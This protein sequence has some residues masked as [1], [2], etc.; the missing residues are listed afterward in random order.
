M[1]DAMSMFGTALLKIDAFLSVERPDGY[2][3]IGQAFVFAYQSRRP[4]P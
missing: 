3:P 2:P 4:A 1:R